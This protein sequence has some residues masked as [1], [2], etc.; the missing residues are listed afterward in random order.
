[1]HLSNNNRKLLWCPLF[2]AGAPIHFG[3]I[4][5]SKVTVSSK[6]SPTKGASE[7]VWY[8][9]VPICPYIEFMVTSAYNYR[10]LMNWGMIKGDVAAERRQMKINGYFLT[11]PTLSIPCSGLLNGSIWTDVFN[12][13]SPKVFFCF[14]VFFILPKEENWFLMFCTLSFLTIFFNIHK[15]TDL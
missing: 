8:K 9:G 10:A 12:A 11:L 15:I 1:M 6:C 4:R 14:K 2:W 3:P 7:S 5:D 13:C